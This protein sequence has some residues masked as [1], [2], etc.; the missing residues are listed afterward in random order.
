MQSGYSLDMFDPAYSVDPYPM[1]DRM[2]EEA[3]I[4]FDPRLHGWLIGRHRDVMALQ[5]EPSLS[6]KRYGY[7]S[8]ALSP[9]LKER[10]APLIDFAATWLTMLDGAEHMRIRKLASSAFQPRF[11]GAMA[12]RIQALCDALI[13]RGNAAGRIELMGELAYPLAQTIIGE[14]VGIPEADRGRMIAWVADLNALLSATIATKERIDQAKESFSEVRSYFTDLVKERRARPVAD[15]LLSN[16]VAAVDEGDRLTTEEV[17]ALVAFLIAGAYDTTSHLIGNAM[18]LLL[19]H[20]DAWAAL[21]EAPDLAASAVEE[22]LRYEPSILVNTR[23]VTQPIE[24]EGFRFEPGH[25]LY[26]LAGAANRD[27]E[28]FPDPTRFD[29]R[30]AENRHISFGFGPHF[31]IGAALARQ[32][33]QIALRRFVALAPGVKLAE[34]SLERAPGFITR[35]LKRLVLELAQGQR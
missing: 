7:M 11:L 25:M 22:V 33:A 12:G 35:P 20:P 14:M 28:V 6:S 15:E 8:A 16:L 26:F 3:P 19:T 21:C 2:R 30:R 9:E 32:E 24:H 18:A 1:L 29:V 34:P 17:V 4:Q 13:E 27:P 5:R 23:L 31:C 10:I